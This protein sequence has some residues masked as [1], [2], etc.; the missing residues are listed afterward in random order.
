MPRK[1]GR[2]SDQ[3]RPIH[4]VPNYTKHAHGSVLMEQ[5]D[6]RVLCTVTVDDGVH[7]RAGRGEDDARLTLVLRAYGRDRDAAHEA[8]ERVEGERRRRVRVAGR[9]ELR[10][11]V[12][13]VRHARD[14]RVDA[15]GVQVRGGQV[16]AAQVVG[17][18]GIE[19]GDHRRRRRHADRV[20]ARRGQRLRDGPN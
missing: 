4:I 14:D 19:L 2:A 9:L 1:D 18:E 10:D 16:D 20:H 6:T 7:A 5:G 15:A 13:A 17:I 8:V 11:K 12:A 3:L